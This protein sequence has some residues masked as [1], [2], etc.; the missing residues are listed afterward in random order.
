MT[1]APV[2]C[3]DPGD[4][5][6]I[7]GYARERVPRKYEFGSA[8][9]ASRELDVAAMS[10][11][12]CPGKWKAEAET[13]DSGAPAASALKGLEDELRGFRR[14]RSS[15]VRDGQAQGVAIAC[16]LDFDQRTTAVLER[17]VEQVS[18]DST[19]QMLVSANQRLVRQA[20]GQR[21][22]VLRQ[23]GDLTA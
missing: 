18:G 3:P 5:S 1:S 22:P 17:V 9:C 7:L 15:T 23:I 20:E 8:S 19:Q 4:Q 21:C 13:G 12:N 14:D 2:S 11:S 10:P 6:P 16:G